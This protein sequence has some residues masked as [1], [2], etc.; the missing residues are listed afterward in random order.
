MMSGNFA[1]CNNQLRGG[2]TML[3]FLL[4]LSTILLGP[5]EYRYLRPEGDKY[6]LES[7]VKILEKETGSQYISKTFRGKQT[8]TLTIQRDREGKPLAAEISNAIDS[9]K[10]TAKL[11]RRGEVFRLTRN[12]VSED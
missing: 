7:D 4:S 11:E 12:G 9:T 2:V 1:R 8:L 5:E 3:G 6:V 10:T